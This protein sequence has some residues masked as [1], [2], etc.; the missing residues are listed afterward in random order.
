MQ[1]GIV[2]WY[3]RSG[4]VNYLDSYD[5][6]YIPPSDYELSL[7]IKL[8]SVHSNTNGTRLLASVNSEKE[9]ISEGDSKKL[10]LPASEAGYYLVVQTSP[11]TDGLHRSQYSILT[12][13]L[14][15]SEIEGIEVTIAAQ[16]WSGAAPL[17]NV[18]IEADTG[19]MQAETDLDGVG[20]LDGISGTSLTMSAQKTITSQDGP[21]VSQAVTLQDAVS[22]L[23]MIAGQPL[24]GE[25]VPIPRAQSLAADFDGSGA[26]SLADAIGVL[27]HAVG[28]QAPAP[29]W[30][31]VEEGDDAGPSALSPG[32]PGAVTVE[33][34]PPGP[35]EINLFGILRGDVDGSYG[36]YPG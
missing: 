26:V 31:F 30:V 4:S 32:I 7:E 24:N 35:I 25:G 18:L 14:I 20:T 19:F 9:Y 3:R 36:V 5:T 16:F 22:I 33:V 23:K 28:L 13:E 2:G 29:S 11:Y 10:T 12:T 27:R 1:L 8:L 15:R 17:A 6:F 34:T 21:A